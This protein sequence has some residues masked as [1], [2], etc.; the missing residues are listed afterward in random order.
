MDTI[1]KCVCVCVDYTLSAIML[2]AI[3]H[4]LRHEKLV[5]TFDAE[6]RCWN[7][8]NWVRFDTDFD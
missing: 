1:L 4:E 3:L 6:K 7:F 5:H 8:W 2:I